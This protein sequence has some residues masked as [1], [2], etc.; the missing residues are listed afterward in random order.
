[1]AEDMLPE[2]NVGL[3]EAEKDDLARMIQAFRRERPATEKEVSP[4]ELQAR[5]EGLQERM[6]QL[7]DWLLKVDRRMDAFHDLLRLFFKKSELMHQRIEAAEAAAR[8]R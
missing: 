4:A 6:A 5:L 3:S 2:L 7:G 1:M 8:D